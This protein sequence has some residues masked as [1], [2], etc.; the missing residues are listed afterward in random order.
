MANI[1]AEVEKIVNKYKIPSMSVMILSGEKIILH[2]FFGVRKMGESDKITSSDSFHLGSCSKAFTATLILKLMDEGKLNLEDSVTKFIKKLDAKK[3]EDIKLK[4][5]LSHT[6]GIDGNVKGEIWSKMFT[7]DI[8]PSSAR[9]LAI[10]YLDKSKRLSKA[11]TTYEYSNLGYMVLGQIVE[12][13]EERSFEEVLTEKFLK[14]FEMNSC[15][16]GPAGR[17]NN[18]VGPWPHYLEE[19][20][21]KFIDPKLVYSDNPPA[22][23]AAGGVSCSQ[24]DWAKFVF[25]IMRVGKKSNFLTEKTRKYISKENL[26]G[27]TYGAWG[28]GESDWS[29]SLL[30]HSGSNTLNYS[31]VI[32]GTDMKFAFLINTNS[33]SQEAVL[34][35]VPFLKDYYLKNNKGTTYLK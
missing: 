18:S 19:D 32:I 3:F 9:D 21:Y 14:P 34:E 20:I 30:T 7:F 1:D 5:L 11:G 2:S 13:V 26:S 10:E 15:S 35:I 31:Y 24:E 22:M 4:H 12:Q 29:G 8:T 6:A 25:F 16:F 33:P 17:S 23:S 28:R 27:Y